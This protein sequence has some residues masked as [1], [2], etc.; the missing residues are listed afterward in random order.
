MRTGSEIIRNHSGQGSVQL[1][2]PTAQ[3][4]KAGERPPT[5]RMVIWTALL[6]LCFS[7]PLCRLLHFAWES[8][9]YSYIVLIPFVSLYLGWTSK[10]PA[11]GS[12]ISEPSIAWA[13]VSF[14]SAV[15]LV[16]GLAVAMRKGWQPAPEDYFAVMMS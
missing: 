13:L 3:P 7:V 4:I 16:A 12:P 11:G 9:L 2:G 6:V 14:I 15:T 5:R 8:E 10:Q 1:S